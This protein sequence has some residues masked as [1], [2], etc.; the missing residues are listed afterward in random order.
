ME[1]PSCYWNIIYL[2]IDHYEMNKQIMYTCGNWSK[3]VRLK[4]RAKIGWGK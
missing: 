2:A 3:L 4:V 1:I